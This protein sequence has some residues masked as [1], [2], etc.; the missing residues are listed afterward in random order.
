VF[1]PLLLS[2]ESRDIAAWGTVAIGFIAFGLFA[3]ANYILNDLLD[4]KSDRL[5]WSKRHRPLASGALPPRLGIMLAI[6]A[7]A[8]SF[9]LLQPANFKTI[10]VLGG[11]GF[12]ALLYSL[13]LKRLPLVD[14]L[15]LSMLLTSRMV[16]GAVI[17]NIEISDVLL[18]FGIFVFA[19]LS[20]AKRYTEVER[21]VQIGG[22][23][24]P[25]R[26]YVPKDLPLLLSMG[27]AMAGIATL[28]LVFYVL[29]DGYRAAHYAAPRW[30]WLEPMLLFTLLGR[31]WLV[32][33]RGQMH[34]DPVVFVT[35]DPSSIAIGCGMA[36][37][38]IMAW[39]L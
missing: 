19:S 35:R 11:Y 20:L 6:A 38:L 29:N 31:L 37:V 10:A 12:L 8:A 33:C 21:V 9:A 27:V 39:V 26:G 24:L 17:V 32:T 7:V 14:I 16:F 28:I 30:L 4:L 34:D 1:V 13:K 5:H 15:A 3:S 36:C 18:V 22:V 2:D 25:G 23:A